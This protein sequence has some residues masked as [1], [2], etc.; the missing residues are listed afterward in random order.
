[1]SADHN[2]WYNHAVGYGVSAKSDATSG[3][4]SCDPDATY[5]GSDNA[6]A[7]VSRSCTD[8][9]GN[10]GSD[11]VGFK[12]DATNPSVTVSL[13]RSADHNGWYNH[14]VGYGVSAKSD[15]TSGIDSCDPDAT[16]G[17][18]DN[19]AASVSRSCTDNAGN[20]GS[21]SVGFKY[22]ATNPGIAFVGQSPAK[23]G[24]GWN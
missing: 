22:D 16:Y 7:S 19:A 23:N 8:N 14:A 12:Y 15:A 13:A 3:I 21:D 10:T 17:G 24:Y 9:A 2:G 1:R 20:T 6:A 11:S 4:D 5:G 18:P